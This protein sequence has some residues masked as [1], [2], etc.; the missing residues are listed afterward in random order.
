MYSNIPDLMMETVHYYLVTILLPII[1][2]SADID[3]KRRLYIQSLVSY[4]VVVVST[5]VSL[6]SSPENI[7]YVDSHERP[8]Q[9]F[10]LK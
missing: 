2:S 8:S 4:S 7:Y 6:I 5:M 3:E 9:I 10:V 1:L